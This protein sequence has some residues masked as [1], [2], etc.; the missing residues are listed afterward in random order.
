M[1]CRLSRVREVN[2]GLVMAVGIIAGGSSSSK[3]SW[4]HVGVGDR[5]K[6][7]SLKPTI[8]PKLPL[9]LILMESG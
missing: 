7:S 1:K 4:S 8:S 2:L 5:R 9:I 6:F 3:G